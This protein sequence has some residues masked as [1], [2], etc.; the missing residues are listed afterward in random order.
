MVS[1]LDRIVRIVG[2][3][4]SWLSFVLVILIV[5]DVA[6]RYAFSVT[7]AASFE[8]EWHLFA[9]VFL[10][11]AGWAFQC[12]KHVRVDV[13]YQRFSHT[14]QAWVNLIGCLCL[15]MPMCL[16][17]MQQGFIFGMNAYRLAETSPDPGGLP[18]RFVIKMAIPLGF[19][20]LFL[21]GVST[22][23]KSLQTILGRYN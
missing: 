22:A 18:Y 23:L 6:L 16:V 9:L 21:Q 14:Q 20:V 7:S 12:D 13:L 19:G 3:A 15:L 10:L 1:I 8:L 17:I 4:V 2:K 5:L 11:S